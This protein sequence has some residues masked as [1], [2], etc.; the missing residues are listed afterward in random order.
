MRDVDQPFAFAKI[1]WLSPE[2]GGRRN[3][4][5][6]GVY[7]VNCF[8]VHLKPRHIGR[9]EHFSVIMQRVNPDSA[10]QW[11]LDFFSHKIAAREVKTGG[12]LAI[13]EGGRLVA[14]AEILS[15]VA[16]SARSSI[17]R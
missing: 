17:P 10:E 14:V 9:S 5:P 8:A 1:E 7:A 16:P 6:A 11:K 12:T 15:L 4:P 13:A 2:A 3:G